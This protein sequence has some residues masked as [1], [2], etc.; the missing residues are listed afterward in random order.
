MKNI[1]KKINPCKILYRKSIL[2]NLYSLALGKF[3]VSP[4]TNLIINLTK[5]ITVADVD[6]SFG[7]IMRTTNMG[8]NIIDNGKSFISSA[9]SPLGE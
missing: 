3:Q 1:K 4:I 7:E 9:S 8:Q 6:M 2:P 5:N